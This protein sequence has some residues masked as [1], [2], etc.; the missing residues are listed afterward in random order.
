MI[1]EVVGTFI[2]GLLFCEAVSAHQEA[3]AIEGQGTVT[4]QTKADIYSHDFS[5]VTQAELERLARVIRRRMFEAQQATFGRKLW[6]EPYE[7]E[8]ARVCH[9]NVLLF[10]LNIALKLAMVGAPSAHRASLKEKFE[11]FLAA[12]P[13]N[14]A[15]D[16]GI[17]PDELFHT[18]KM[19]VE[20]DQF[21]S[22][23][24]FQEIYRS[25]VD[26]FDDNTM[27]T[28]AFEDLVARH[29]CSI[30][31]RG[32]LLAGRILDQYGWP[33]NIEFG[34]GV[35]RA[36]FLLLQHSDLDVDLQLRGLKVLK[37]KVDAG[38][39][40]KPFQYAYLY[41]RVGLKVRGRQKYGSQ[42]ECIDGEYYQPSPL[43][44]PE[45]LDE[46]RAEM[47]MVPIQEYLAMVPGCGN[48]LPQLN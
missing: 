39:L 25:I 5:G 32:A 45:K 42:V 2:A 30:S 46:L 11:A 17:A 27:L 40:E 1:C 31:R 29:N 15:V 3:L 26:S 13:K 48:A 10:E 23:Y 24:P 41:D 33:S 14:L 6:P 37:E 47:G 36:M 22:S 38:K 35:E 9:D 7:D 44:E 20:V 4:F 43:E 16:V 12:A 21:F 34:T 18:L 28:S 8:V 19:A